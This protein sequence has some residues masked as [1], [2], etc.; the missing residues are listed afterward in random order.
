MNGWISYYV[1]SSAEFFALFYVILSYTNIKKN[2]NSTWLLN[3]NVAAFV[4]VV[5]SFSWQNECGD[6]ELEPFFLDRAC[7]MLAPNN[8]WCWVLTRERMREPNSARSRQLVLGSCEGNTRVPQFS[9][10]Q[11]KKLWKTRLKGWPITAIK[12]FTPLL[13]LILAAQVSLLSFYGLGIVWN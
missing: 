4:H 2:W 13:A 12:C 7:P 1:F 11:W 10:S 9:C 5:R 8:S 3:Q 6:L